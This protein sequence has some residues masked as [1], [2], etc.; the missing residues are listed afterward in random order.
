M[1]PSDIA[2]GLFGR[3]T[4]L[5]RAGT[6]GAVVLVLL[7]LA[8]AAWI[9][10]GLLQRH[11]A[12]C[13]FVRTAIASGFDARDAA[14]LWLLARFLPEN[15][16][17]EVLSSRDLFEECVRNAAIAAGDDLLG[18]PEPL[19]ESRIDSLR[20]RYTITRRPPTGI[21]D[22]R[23]IEPNQP[24]TLHVPDGGR[25]AGFVLPSEPSR[26]RVTVA[27][28]SRP[29]RLGMDQPIRVTFARPRDARYEFS[30]EVID[31]ETH[32]LDL[33]HVSVKRI[34]QR[35]RVRVRCQEEIHWTKRNGAAPRPN[36]WPVDP[37]QERAMLHDISGGGA[38]F[39]T[40]EK[41][42]APSRLMVTLRRAS[43]AEPIA[44]PAVVIRQVP[45]EGTSQTMYQTS[46]RFDA[47]DSRHEYYL[48]RMVSDLQQ[49]L[50]RRMLARSGE[51]EPEEAP[52]RTALKVPVKAPGSPVVA[53]PQPAPEAVD[54]AD[55][56]AEA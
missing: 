34:Q 21:S 15:R 33:R 3:E 46:V 45:L 32:A 1:N 29:V 41:I 12:R 50:I 27:A 51:P 9:V 39:V 2:A 16:R 24:V 11:A 37:L 30:S 6:I 19:S 44:V 5:S 22:T 25:L 17:P 14:S 55:A 35:S 53:A 42:D 56:R 23:E 8:A 26:L 7:G 38:C 36:S 28:K 54:F 18:W 31:E 43:N 13:A 4:P 49:K 10:R 40:T 52:I 48:S 47:L 20:R